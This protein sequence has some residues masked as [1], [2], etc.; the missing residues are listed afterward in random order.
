MVLSF[1]I[2]DWSCYRYLRSE[3]TN[4]K[5]K[6]LTVITSKV[7]HPYTHGS[8]SPLTLLATKLCSSDIFSQSPSKPILL[9]QVMRRCFLAWSGVT[10]HSGHV[11]IVL[12]IFMH[13]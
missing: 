13:L 9:H 3:L 5:D 12:V 7:T 8:T 1:P 4:E 10:F 2:F 6:Y 11:L